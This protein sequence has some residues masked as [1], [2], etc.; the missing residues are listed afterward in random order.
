MPDSFDKQHR[1]A[2]ARLAKVE[3]RLRRPYQT[4]EER[5]RRLRLGDLRKLFHDRYGG[6]KL[7][8]DDAGRSDLRDLLATIALGPE[9]KARDKMNEEISI[10]ARWL[11]PKAAERMIAGILDQPRD[12]L[13]VKADT[14]AQRQNVTY[15]LR[16]RLG[17]KTIGAIDADK[18]ERGARRKAKDRERKRREREAKGAKSRAEY[19]SQSANRNKPWLAAGMS[20]AKFYRLKALGQPGP[21]R[22]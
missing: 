19:E 22:E 13:K 14:L 21:L 11:D 9:E 2:I 4:P 5:F 7:P 3:A 1:S 8:D 16:E 20:R 15:E 10:V 12:C 17:L 18:E 6:D